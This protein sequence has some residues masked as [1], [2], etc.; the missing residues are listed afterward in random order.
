MK[1]SRKGFNWLRVTLE[2]D[3]QISIYMYSGVCIIQYNVIVLL[4]FACA[5]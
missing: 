4:Q 5:D 2:W 3:E 1:D